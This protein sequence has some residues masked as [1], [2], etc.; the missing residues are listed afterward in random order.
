MQAGE[1]VL[2]GAVIQLTTQAPTDSGSQSHG[3]SVHE[4]REVIEQGR[5]ACSGVGWA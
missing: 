2:Q 3:L 4:G 5:P 1:G